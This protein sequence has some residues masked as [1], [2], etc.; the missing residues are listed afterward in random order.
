MLIAGHSP[1]IL[2][3]ILDSLACANRGHPHIHQTI[4]LQHPLPTGYTGVPGLRDQGCSSQSTKRMVCMEIGLV[5][6]ALRN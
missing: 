4:R 1:Y 2:Y 6:K 3:A 5:D